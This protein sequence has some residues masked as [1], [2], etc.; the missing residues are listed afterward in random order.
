MCTAVFLFKLQSSITGVV[1][2]QQDLLGL[3]HRHSTQRLFLLPQCP[4]HAPPALPAWPMSPLLAL[5]TFM[6][7]SLQLISISP[8]CGL[9]TLHSEVNRSYGHSPE[10]MVGR[11]QLWNQIYS[12]SFLVFT[13]PDHFLMVEHKYHK[14]CIYARWVLAAKSIRLLWIQEFTWMWLLQRLS[15]ALN[16]S[17]FYHGC[18][19]KALILR[20]RTVGCFWQEGT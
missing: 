12:L 7:W 10:E 17:P 2:T 3:S 11:Y 18:M 8:V 16:C 15:M 4:A 14:H 5:G 6:V 20:L 9:G 13:S 19:N 1:V